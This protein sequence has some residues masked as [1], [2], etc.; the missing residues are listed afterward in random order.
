[1]RVLGRALQQRGDP[2]PIPWPEVAIRPTPG[3]VV[4]IT[5]G[6]GAGK[7][8][9][10][11]N[12]VTYL[13]EKGHP[14]VYI[15]T[16][17]SYSDQAMRTGA[18]LTGALVDDIAK[19]LDW[20]SAWLH[21]Q[22]EL[23]IRWSQL[24]MVAADIPD[25][26]K[27]EIEF[28]GETPILVVVDVLTDMLGPAE[29]T[30]GEIRRIVREWKKAAKRFQTTVIVLHHIKRGGAVAN[31]TSKVTLQDGLYGGE[32]DATHV[33]GIWRPASETLT[34]AT[35]KNRMGLANADGFLQV[36]LRADY[37]HARISSRRAVFG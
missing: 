37:P 19:K 28:L 10:A 16:D 36:D 31:G 1:M 11:L 9:I 15:S 7:S 5:A 21:E 18:L 25:F 8:T 29:E 32:Q 30:V 33:L 27:A 4:L 3:D 2:I 34:V 20:W 17:T 23:P 22:D 12:W 35:L 24:S 14:V 26:M 13:A 6:P